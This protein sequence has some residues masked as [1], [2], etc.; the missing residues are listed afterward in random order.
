MN[1]QTV[2]VVSNNNAATDNVYEKLEKYNLNYLCA[3]LG[4]KENKYDFIN[5]QTGKYPKFSVKLQEKADIENKVVN[6]NQ[7]LSEVKIEHKYFNQY[8]GNNLSDMP[9]IRNLNRVTSDI[10]MRLKAELEEL[11]TR[12][13]LF[14][15]K[16]QFIYG[17]GNRE[18]YKKSKKE[19]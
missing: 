14:R 7:E 3:R 13:I 1:G 4:K 8:E 5:K 6:L 18:F 11:N 17:I 9:K 16:S 10:I 15:L 12:G 2:A 19:L